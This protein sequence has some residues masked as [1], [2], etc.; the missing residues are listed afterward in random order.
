M[1]ELWQLKL[2]PGTSESKTIR[3]VLAEENERKATEVVGRWNIAININPEDI[4]AK[5]KPRAESWNSNT[6]LTDF[7]RLATLD[8]L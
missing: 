2:Y 8:L 5:V 4:L 7:S 6:R 3:Q 1:P